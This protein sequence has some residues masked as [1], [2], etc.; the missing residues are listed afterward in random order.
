[1]RIKIAGQLTPER[2]AEA[3][4]HLNTTFKAQF[5]DDFAGFFGGNLY[6]QGFLKDGRSCEIQSRGKEVV[7]SLRLPPG[8]IARPALSES[9]KAEREALRQAEAARAKAE[10]KRQDQ[11]RRELDERVAEERALRKQAMADQ[12]K[13]EQKFKSVVEKFGDA[14]IDDC[15]AVIKAVWDEHQPVWPNGPKKGQVRATPYLQM[16]DGFVFLYSG[17]TLDRGRK[18]K[19]PIS[20]RSS[21]ADVRTFW[22]YPEWKDVAVP[23]LSRVIERYANQ[24]TDARGSISGDHHP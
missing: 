9:V 14:V 20:S 23:A 3:I 10:Q 17:T 2:L 8:E 1:M 13:R 4:E 7:L 22:Q 18:I 5:G 11:M 15:N 12:D 19:T 24:L 16:I 6:V 21:H